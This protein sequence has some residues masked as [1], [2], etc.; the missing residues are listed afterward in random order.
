MAVMLATPG[1]V[2][3]LPHPRVVP[4][5]GSLPASD[6]TA[7]DKAPSLGVRCGPAVCQGPSEPRAASGRVRP[8]SPRPATALRSLISMYSGVRPANGSSVKSASY[9]CFLFT[10]SS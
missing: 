4:P 6:V 3:S 9:R 5:L 8:A 10:C 1:L 7:G 2:P